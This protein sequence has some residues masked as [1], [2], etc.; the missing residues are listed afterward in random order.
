MG[1]G[2]YIW[3]V[4]WPEIEELTPAPTYYGEDTVDWKGFDFTGIAVGVFSCMIIGVLFGICW[5]QVMKKFAMIIIKGMLFFNI[6]VWFVVGIMGFVLPDSISLAVI[7]FIIA[8]FCY[9]FPL[10]ICHFL[11]TYNSSLYSDCL[12]TWCIW[13]RIPFAS[14]LLV[15]NGYIFDFKIYGIFVYVR[16]IAL[17][18]KYR[19]L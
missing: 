14:V 8:L 2:I 15:C 18:Y 17:Y 19:Y 16:I 9:V 13:S 3:I 1:V 11:Q 12:W 7:G 10:F 5:L 6:A 4:E